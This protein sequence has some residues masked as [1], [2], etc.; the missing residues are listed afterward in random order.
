MVYT[1]WQKRE[2]GWVL[3]GLYLLMSPCQVLLLLLRVSK[4]PIVSAIFW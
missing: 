1:I 4:L 3:G 2:D